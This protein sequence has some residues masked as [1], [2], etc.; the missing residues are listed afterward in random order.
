MKK[1]Y[2]YFIAPLVGLALFG[3][4]Y[5]QYA[6]TYEEKVARAEKDRRDKIEAKV[7]TDN[8]AKR[9]A[10]EAA[11]IAQE[12]RKAAKKEK[13]DREQREKDER[14]RSNQMRSKAIDDA[15][16]LAEQAER[17][18][19]SVAETEKENAKIETEKKQLVAEEAH[20]R[21]LVKL[22]QANRKNLEVVLEKIDAA[23]KVAAANAKAQAQAQAAAAA[24]AKK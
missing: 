4:V 18:K 12:Q 17:L 19:K 20:F 22:S 11:L 16:K 3:V 15:G 14:E 1:S 9:S 5:W 13:E 10:V 24:A 23:E 7:K 2:L 6:S 8:D 21:E